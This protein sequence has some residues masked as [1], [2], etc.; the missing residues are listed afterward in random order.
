MEKE[1]K[2]ICRGLY[3]KYKREIDLI[4]ENAPTITA[5]L[6]EAVDYINSL[7]AKQYLAH[8][9]SDWLTVSPCDW[10][11]DSQLRET[12]KYSSVRLEFN[13]ISENLHISFVVP[14]NENNLSFVKKES[15]RLLGRDFKEVESWKNW[16]KI[17]FSMDKFEDFM[18]ESFV[19]DWDDKVKHYADIFIQKCNEI[20]SKVSLDIA[21]NLCLKETIES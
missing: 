2:A 1:I 12:R 11:S 17:F 9:G 4:V 8:Y 20:Y 18:P 6:K 3:S 19:A 10:M 5:F 15:T 7:P 14:N 16:G 13:Y 21:R